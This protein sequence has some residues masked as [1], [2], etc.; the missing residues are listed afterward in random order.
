VPS[1]SP[2]NLRAFVRRNTQLV[3]IPDVPGVRLHVAD[4][5]AT[6]WRKAGEALDDLDPALPY[7][8]FAW[9]GGLALARHLVECP[10]EVAGRRVLDVGT[11]SGL[12][13]IVAARAGA[14]S[15]LAADIDLLAVAAA[16]VNARANDVRV[17][18]TGDDLLARDPPAVDVILAGDV[19]YE[20]AMAARMFEWL[21][22]AADVGIR[23]LIGDPGRKYLRPGLEQIAKYPVHPSPEIE[24]ASVREASVFAFVRP[25]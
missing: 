2:A 8:A 15:V 16:A 20:E 14:S 21:G 4:D 1:P 23:V 22:S 24:S 18:V 6:V 11:G 19:S 3:G 12:C 9:S 7:W 13:A 25:R 10:A 5:V 17:G